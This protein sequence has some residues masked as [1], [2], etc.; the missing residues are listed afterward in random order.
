MLNAAEL[1]LDLWRVIMAKST[2]SVTFGE[3]GVAFKRSRNI[4]LKTALREAGWTKNSVDFLRERQDLFQISDEKLGHERV[5]ALARDASDDPD[6]A[7]AALDDDLQPKLGGYEFYRSIGSPRH[8][9]AP[10]VEQSELPF[11][12]LVRRYGTHVCYTPM[13]HSRLFTTNPTYR[14]GAFDTLP[15]DRPLFAQV[16]DCSEADLWRL[17]P[18]LRRRVPALLSCLAAS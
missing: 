11:R 6:P 10:M 2:A 16:S 7:A 3:V 9:L 14:A 12:T 13:I 5:R 15:T 1:Q 8:V 18:C 4:D 17:Q